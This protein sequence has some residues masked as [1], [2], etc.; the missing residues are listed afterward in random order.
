MQN[1][2]CSNVSYSVIKM[3]EDSGYTSLTHHIDVNFFKAMIKSDIIKLINTYGHKNC[4]LRHEELCDEI[5]KI[6]TDNKRIVFQYMN[7]RGKTKWIKDWDSQRSIYFNKLFQEEGFINMCFPT[8]YKNNPRLY[9]LLSKHIQFCKEKDE[10]L[11]ALK[12]TSEFSVCKQYNMWIDTQRTSFT[13]EYLKN[14]TEFTSK[15]VHKYFSTKEHPGGHDPRVTYL[16]SKL[17]CNQYNPPTRSHPQGP[18]EKAPKSSIPLPTSPEVGQESQGKGGKPM[19]DRGGGIQ[20]KKSDVM[21]PPPTEPPASDT[22]KS[23]QSNTKVDDDTA[24]GQDDDLKTKGTGLPNNAQDATGIQTETIDTKAK[25]PQ[26]FPVP[27]S[28]IS[29]IDLLAASVPD[30][31]PSVTKDQST[32]SN[33]TPITTSAT[34]DTTH[35]IQNVPSSS[36]PDLSLTQLQPTAAAAVSDQ[37]SQESTPPGPVSKSPD[38]DALLTSTLDPGLAPSQAAATNSIASETSSSTMTLTPG[39]SLGQ[40]SHLPTPTQPI[41]TTSVATTLTPTT[42]SVSDSTTITVSAMGSKPIQSIIEIKSKTVESGEPNALPKT[43]TGSQDLK[44]ASP[45]KQDGALPANTGTNFPDTSSSL[46]SA[47]SNVMLLP[48]PSSGPHFLLLSVPSSGLSS[49]VSPAGHPPVLPPSRAV[50]I[51]PDSNQIMTSLKDVPQ[52]SKNSTQDSSTSLPKGTQP[53]DKSIITQT[54]FPPLTSI[55]PTIVI[56]LATTTLLFLLYKY[57]PFGFLLG[58]RRKRKKRNLRRT[59]VIPEKP[60]YE[61]SNIVAHEWEDP[62]LVGKTVENDVYIKLLKINRYKQEMQNR[63]KKNKKT[64]IEVHMEVLEEYKSDEWELHKGDFLEICLRGFINE[65]NDTYLKLPNSELTINN[66]NEKTIED[67]QK[68][69]ILW[70]NWRRSQQGADSQKNADF[71]S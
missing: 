31:L 62:K 63:K 47:N 52:Q 65:E 61:S 14:V 7:T 28:S 67:I 48:D 11:S 35:S 51:K 6:I 8:K 55:I 42:T 69:E 23:P 50:V 17:D 37:Y 29:P 58:R 26:Q 4:G 53:S 2:M 40:D 49:D 71:T 18:V 36:A 9:Q 66:I 22:Q 45:K 43:I 13:R 25:S 38:Q 57:T 16:K 70:N 3:A 33:S 60:T 20:K 21:I 41:V 10:R 24:N 34:S 68:Q 5:R 64:L 44:I 54:K 59:F 32:V 19:P 15:N 1:Y 30:T 56:I 39:S 46:T 27:P 12:K